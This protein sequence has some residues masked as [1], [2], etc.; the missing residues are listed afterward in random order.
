MA[1]T[2]HRPS[3]VYYNLT[4]KKML[5]KAKSFVFLLCLNKADEQKKQF[6]KLFLTNCG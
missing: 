4:R 5:K 6:E 1:Q 3:E 2:D